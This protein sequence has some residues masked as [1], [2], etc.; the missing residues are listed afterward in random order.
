MLL[1]LIARMDSIGYEFSYNMFV[2]TMQTIA[3][4]PDGS[5]VQF[6][7]NSLVNMER[8]KPRSCDV[9]VQMLLQRLARFALS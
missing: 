7:I 8:T 5:I 9:L 4:D 2:F 6:V 1:Q 3:D